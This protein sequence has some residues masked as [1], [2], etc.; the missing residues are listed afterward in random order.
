MAM[1]TGGLPLMPLTLH[2][3][4]T[5]TLRDAAA[6]APTAVDAIAAVV[7]AAVL[8]DATEGIAGPP[9]RKS[10]AST[11]DGQAASSAPSVARHDSGQLS[12]RAIL[13][14]RLLGTRDE[15]Q[16]AAF[17]AS[18]VGAALLAMLRE[19]FLHAAW[20]VGGASAQALTPTNVES[21]FNATGSTLARPALYAAQLSVPQRLPFAA[22]TV[23]YRTLLDAV[24]TEREALPTPNGVSVAAWLAST[25]A[26]SSTPLG[27]SIFERTREL[28]S[29][30]N[31]GSSGASGASSSSASTTGTTEPQSP[32]HGQVP[33]PLPLPLPP[34]LPSLQADATLRDNLVRI[35]GATTAVS[36]SDAQR[37]AI[38]D[39]LE[40]SIGLLEPTARPLLHERLLDAL[41]H[42]AGAQLLA[43][44]L[45]AQ[46]RLSDA[47]ARDDDRI[48]VLLARLL[49]GCTCIASM[50]CSAVAVAEELDGDAMAAI[51]G[52]GGD[53]G[54]DGGGSW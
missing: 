45:D 22:A 48:D 44:L 51:M 34:P 39:G 9:K 43:Q 46:P 16:L 17:A 27:R 3:M 41:L 50:Q 8:I 24:A 47:S 54:D 26:T 11:A 18:H 14:S 30:G 10:T 53:D 33:P 19:T 21:I 6:V 2:R 13:L 7:P 37:R 42:P 36:L 28:L 5:L 23:V 32:S 35:V 52:G 29:A 20:A 15:A 40:R 31:A 25:G 38:D 1:S 4:A 12:V 49:S